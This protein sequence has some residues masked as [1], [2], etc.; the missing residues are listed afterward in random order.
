MKSWRRG[1]MRC[2][3]RE[4]PCGSHQVEARA[5]KWESSVDETEEGCGGGGGGAGQEG[6]DW[7]RGCVVE[8]GRL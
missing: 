8:F 1:F 7:G 5:E 3:R 2:R 4:G 6:C